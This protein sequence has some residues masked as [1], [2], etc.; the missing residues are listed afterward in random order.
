MNFD[1]D[2][3]LLKFSIESIY[4]SKIFHMSFLYEPYIKEGNFE[5]YYANT[6]GMNTEGLFCACHEIEPYIEG[7]EHPRS[8]EIHI[9]DQYEALTKYSN[10]ED[11]KNY[12]NRKT[13]V[14]F[15]GPSLHNL[16]ADK[17]GKAFVSETNDSHNIL[18]DMESNFIIMSNFANYTLRGKCYKDAIG[19]G[20]ERYQIAYE[21]ISKNIDSFNINKGFTLLEKLRCRDIGWK[22]YCSMLFHPKTNTI[23]IA[24]KLNMERVWRISLLDQTVET[25][26]GYRQYEKRGIEEQ[27][28]SSKELEMLGG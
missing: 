5:D 1:F 21:Y 19:V 16:F 18:T 22:T 17:N 28:I 15:K 6:C 3:I 26:I 7:Y 9:G 4:R 27:G 14:Q 20:S 2:F 10:I 11:T 12:I 24:L 25:F 8:G 13:A 23:Y